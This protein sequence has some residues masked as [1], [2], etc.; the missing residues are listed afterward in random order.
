MAEVAADALGEEQEGYVVWTSGGNDKQGFHMKWESWP[1][2]VF[3]YYWVKD[4]PIIDQ[5]ELEREGI[6][7]AN[8]SILNLVIVKK[9][10]KIAG[11][12]DIPWLTNTMMPDCLG[13]Q[14]SKIHKLFN[15]SKED[16]VSQ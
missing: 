14:S 5:G 2:A 1:R 9:K 6:V 10:K 8:L 12:R 16:D 15:H 11:G 13:T 7:D 3:T 4:T